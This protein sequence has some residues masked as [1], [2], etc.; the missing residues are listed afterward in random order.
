MIELFTGPRIC[1]NLETVI[2]N[3]THI[4]LNSQTINH[5]N[6]QINYTVS[7]KTLNSCPWLPHMLP[8]SVSVKEFWE[9]LNN[10]G[11]YSKSLVYYFFDYWCT[12]ILTHNSSYIRSKGVHIKTHKYY[13]F[14]TSNYLRQYTIPLA[15]LHTSH[16]SA[17]LDAS[18]AYTLRAPAW[19]AK[20]DRM[21]EPAPTSRTTWQQQAHKQCKMC[22]Q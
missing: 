18:T 21:P 2:Q 4:H 8:V 14:Q 5:K 15:L 13:N 1:C 17:M 9:S 20:K 7:Q 22:K 19:I 12:S 3:N 10:W 16:C 6:L 11:S